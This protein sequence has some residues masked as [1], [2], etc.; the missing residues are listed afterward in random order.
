MVWLVSDFASLYFREGRW[1]RTYDNLEDDPVKPRGLMDIRVFGLQPHIQVIPPQRGPL[2]VPT[3]VD[4]TSSSSAASAADSE[5]EAR[6]LARAVAKQT[7]MNNKTYGQTASPKQSEKGDK[8]DGQ[9]SSSPQGRFSNFGGAI[10]NNSHLIVE[11]SEGVLYRLQTGPA[12]WR[13]H[14]YWTSTEIEFKPKVVTSPSHMYNRTSSV[15]TEMNFDLNDEGNGVGG[16][17]GNGSISNNA[18]FNGAIS[19]D[20]D[21]VDRYQEILVSGVAAVITDRF[22]P[23]IHGGRGIRGASGTGRGVA[24]ILDNISLGVRLENRMTSAGIDH[25]DIIAMMPWGPGVDLGM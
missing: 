9:S 1:G 21:R 8:E 19:P 20:E 3:C 14:R 10:A 12:R 4:N 23:G 25:R 15:D 17:G 2:Y 24:T 13:S 22:I 5:Y 6:R 11:G 7:A 16:G 18:G